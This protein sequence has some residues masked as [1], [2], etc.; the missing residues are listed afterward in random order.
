MTAEFALAL[1]AVLACVALCIGAVHGAAQFGALAAGAASAARLAG[2]GDDPASAPVPAGTGMNVEREG[3]A[4]CVVM[5][6]PENGALGRLGIRLS[7]RACALD[8]A[9]AE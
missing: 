4:V 2:R 9:A 1:P 3:S 6:A 7:A 5:T 8:E